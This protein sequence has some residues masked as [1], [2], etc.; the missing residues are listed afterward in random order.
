MFQLKSGN[1]V[2]TFLSGINN[3]SHHLEFP[4]GP[5][6]QII[7]QVCSSHASLVFFK[8]EAKTFSCMSYAQAYVTSQLPT[9]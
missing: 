9:T 2:G 5:E 1:Q 7:P 3:L 6:G 8:Y 4:I